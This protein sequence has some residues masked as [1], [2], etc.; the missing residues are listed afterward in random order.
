[1]RELISK[2][3]RLTYTVNH[4]IR[5]LEL[6]YQFKHQV[7]Y[8]TFRE[9]C[10]LCPSPIP[11]R[12]S[13]SPKQSIQIKIALSRKI[14]PSKEQSD[15]NSRGTAPK[16]THCRK[17]SPNKGLLMPRE[18]CRI[19]RIGLSIR[20]RICPISTPQFD[21]TSQPSSRLNA[22]CNLKQNSLFNLSNSTQRNARD[23]ASA[24]H[25]HT[26]QAT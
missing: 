19:C 7:V 18:L 25:N 22:F 17:P 2:D 23:S 26:P 15:R 1:M 10:D 8:S 9:F 4:R 24:H 20:C 6:K 13:N 3:R 21:Q 16:G 5:S 12:L 14:N 11:T